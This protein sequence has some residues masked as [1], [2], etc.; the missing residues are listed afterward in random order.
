MGI[1]YS[2]NGNSIGNLLQYGTR[3]SKSRRGDTLADVVVDDDCGNSVEDD[4]ECLKHDQSLRKIARFL[5]FSDQTEEGD[6]SAV[7]EHDISNGT[8]GTEKIGIDG[9]LEANATLVLNADSNH[10]D[11]N[12]GQDTD[13][14]YPKKKKNLVIIH[15]SQGIGK[16]YTCMKYRSCSS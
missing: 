5:H 14:G 1:T 4:L 11:D 7:S 10:G 12:S 16:T 3:R 15:K 9:G 8:E 13:E 2:R 6:V